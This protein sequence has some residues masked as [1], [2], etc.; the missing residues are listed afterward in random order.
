MENLRTWTRQVGL[1]EDVFP[2][3][4]PSRAGSAAP[5]T[6]RTSRPLTP[7]DD[8]GPSSSDIRADSDSDDEPDRTFNTTPS[9]DDMALLCREGG[10]KFFQLLLSK[11]DKLDGPIKS[12]ICDWT[13]RDLAR[14]SKSEQTEWK[15]ACQEQ[16]EALRRCNVF[17]LVDK[18]K[19][20]RVVKNRWVFNVKSDSRK[21]AWLVAR[22][23]SQIEGVDFD[24]IFSPVVRYETVRLICALAALE[25]WHMSAL[26]VRNAY[27]YGELSEEIY[28]EQPEGYKAPGKEHKV[29]R[30]HKALYGLKQTGL[31]W[32]RTLDHSMKDLG[33]RRL[34]SNAGLFIKYDNGERI[35]V[36]V[37]VD[38]ALFCGPNK[39]K[40]LKAKQDFMFKW[41]CRDLGDATNF[42]RMRITRKGD[43]LSLD[44]VDY[45]DKILDRF[46]MV[47]CKSARTPLPE[48]YQPLAN[49]GPADSALRSQFQQVIGS[50]LYIMLG[51]R[52]NIAFAVTKLAQQSANPTK[53]HL[54][55]A[56]HIL[57]YLNSTRNYTLDYD[58]KS[59]LGLV[60]FVDLDW[61]SDPNTRQSQTGFLL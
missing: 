37:Y 50:L 27:L 36:V 48:G 23:F 60:A 25:K 19:G 17:E 4:P 61:G 58:G 22:G 33:F 59:G 43:K 15:H 51:T 10:V 54:S 24:Q 11:A 32:W 20:K 28:M 26:D 34:V 56:K 47:N 1:K 5:D 16:L 12:N 2:S 38:D 8:A 18:P 53:N 3:N 57:A 49:T 6:P 9:D 7:R 35:V 39:A 46:G 13:F 31:T 30:L 14:L 45:L 41:E 44:Q 29:L 21:Q 55:K 52:P 42:L 40:V